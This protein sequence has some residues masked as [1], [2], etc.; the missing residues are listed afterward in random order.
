MTQDNVR[1][2]PGV[3]KEEIDEELRPQ[4]EARITLNNSLQADLEIALVLGY[5][6]AGNLYLA[7]NM[8]DG[9]ELLWLLERAKKRLL[10][11]F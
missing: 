7:T 2:F 10:E 8:Q 4:E 6:A 1:L 9:P 5:N 3:T 11:D